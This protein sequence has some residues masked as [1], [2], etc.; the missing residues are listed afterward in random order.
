MSIG[1]VLYLTFFLYYH[2]MDF[3]KRV[4]LQVK[5][6]KMTIE[7]LMNTVLEKKYSRDIYQGWRRRQCLPKVDVCLKMADLLNVSVRYLV[8]GE[9]IEEDAFKTQFYHHKDF[10]EKLDSLTQADYKTVEKFVEVLA[11]QVKKPE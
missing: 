8:T 3:Y 11:N 2:C 6:N 4:K 1:N 7:Y 9:E 10:L 5:R